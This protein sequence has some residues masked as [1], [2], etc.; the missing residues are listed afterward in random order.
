MQEVKDKFNESNE[1]K[2]VSL[3]DLIVL[4]GTAAVEKAARD[5]GYPVKVPFTLGR[6][7]ATQE[8]TDVESHMFCKTA[9]H[10]CSQLK[11]NRYMILTGL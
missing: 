6:V 1:E 9:P 11:S 3:A 4:G 2:Q 8:D 5:A 7:D 10:L